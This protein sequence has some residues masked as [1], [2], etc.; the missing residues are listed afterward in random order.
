MTQN[1]STNSFYYI[2]ILACFAIGILHTLFAC[3][4]YYGD[5]LTDGNIG[6]I[7]I[8]ENHLMWALPLFLMITGALLL[9]PEK[10][11]DK[12]KI[13]K[14]LSRIIAALIFFTFVFQAYEYLFEEEQGVLF[15]GLKKLVTGTGWAHMWYL[16]LMIGIYLMIPIY[17]MISRQAGSGE[18]LYFIALLVIFISV[19]PLGKYFDF[20]VGFYIPT[21]LIYPAYL[22]IGYYFCNHPMKR[23]LAV[24]LFVLSTV[25]IFAVTYFRF[26]N[27]QD[28]HTADL[29]LGYDSLLV[30][31]Q[32]TAVFCILTG[33]KRTPG[34]IILAIDKCTFGIYIIHMIFIRLVFKWFGFN[35]FEYGM[36]K[37]LSV[38]ILANIVIFT[39]S[40]CITYT[41]RK[42]SKGRAF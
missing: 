37:G 33:I 5:T 14:Y 8:I 21:T 25:L 27:T 16:Y 9:N 3:F 15:E 19:L 23:S 28:M 20:N 11:I 13:I 26:T 32:S 41:V 38:I 18:L 39:V 24:I 7:Q 17:R 35:P 31:L 2:R 34:K 12:G 10:E 29:T 30:V 36:A 40:M 6:L 22:F 1:Y 4:V 42:I